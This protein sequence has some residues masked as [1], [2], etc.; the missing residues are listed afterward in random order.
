MTPKWKQYNFYL[1]G[2]KYIMVNSEK[3]AL[4]KSKKKQTADASNNVNKISLK[5]IPTMGL[6]LCGILE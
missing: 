6:H 2:N 3:T 5:R 4:F 1:Q